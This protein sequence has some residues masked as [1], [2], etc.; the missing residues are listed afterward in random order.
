[1]ILKNVSID[2]ARGQRV[3]I[4]GD[5]GAGKTTLLNVL[6]ERLKPTSGSVLMGH[7][8][9]MGYFGQH[10]LDELSLDDT[11]FDNLRSRAVGVS[12]EELRGWLGAFGFLGDDEIN[13]KARVLS[14]GERAR[15]AMLRILTSRINVCL[16]DE[17]TN[18]LDI[19]TKELLKDAIRN[20]EGTS[21]F[22]S[23]DR[24]FVG[25][26]A[27]RILYLTSDH[28]LIDHLGNLETFF[29]KFPQ[30][31]RHL[32]GHRAAPS[33]AP[34]DKPKAAASDAPKISFEDRKKY[35]NQAKSLQKKIDSTESEME[36][37]G[38]RKDEIARKLGEDGLPAAQSQTL[39]SELGGLDE[40]L[41]SL[42]SEWEKMSTELERIRQIV[43]DLV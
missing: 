23:H 21:V 32:E 27:E 25:D 18:H 42:M 13:K 30:Y 37:L 14:G 39:T 24:E 6:A 17:P 28:K 2:I 38:A 40:R 12:Y 31:V 19:E 36:S 29:E 41:R 26:I 5:N 16:L 9:L 22:V 4:M 8:V 35:K 34:A 33:Q 43:P 7:N 15:L 1:L 11:V 10:Q 3:A 20:F